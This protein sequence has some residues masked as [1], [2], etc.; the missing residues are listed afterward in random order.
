[1]ERQAQTSVAKRSCG[2]ATASSAAITL[3]SSAVPVEGFVRLPAKEASSLSTKSSANPDEEGKLVAADVSTRRRAMVVGR[4]HGRGALLRRGQTL[5]GRALQL[6]R[7][8]VVVDLAG[9]EFPARTVR[10]TLEADSMPP[11]GAIVPCCYRF[12][13]VFEEY[14]R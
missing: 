14:L 2:G 12:T 13:L 7:R 8:A 6:T 3:A 5:L 11:V 1:M 4:G 9:A 10:D